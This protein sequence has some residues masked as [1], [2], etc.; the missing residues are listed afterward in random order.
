MASLSGAGAMSSSSGSSGGVVV[1]LVERRCLASWSWCPR[2][3]GMLAG[4]CFEIRLIVSPGKVVRW[5]RRMARSRVEG[6]GQ[7]RVA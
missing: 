2:A 6:T 1:P 4:R 3:V 7:P 5:P